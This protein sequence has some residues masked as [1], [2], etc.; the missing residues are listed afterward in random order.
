[1]LTKSG[2][3][4]GMLSAAAIG[5]LAPSAASAGVTSA[6]VTSALATGASSAQSLRQVWTAGADA[7]W[8][9]TQGE[10]LGSAQALDRTVD[11]GRTW[12][13]V[14]PPGLGK[15]GAYPLPSPSAARKRYFLG[16]PGTS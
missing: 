5:V 1:M 14:T 2:A 9:W 15:H 7:A 12:S 6:R 11:G 16:V 3:I 8:A 10:N 13:T 4:T